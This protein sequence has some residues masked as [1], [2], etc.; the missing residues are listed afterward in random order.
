MRV[1]FFALILSS[2]AF[3]TPEKFTGFHLLNGCDIL[4]LDGKILKQIPGFHC[5]PMED[6][7]LITA[8]DKFIRLLRADGSIA[9]EIPGIFH[10]QINLSPDKK[11]ILAL[12]S[13]VFNRGGQKWREDKFFVISTEGNIL[14]QNSVRELIPQSEHIQKEIPQPM[15]RIDSVG[16][17][18]SHF[19]SI[20]EIPPGH[21]GSSDIF[22]EGHIVVNSL[23]MGIYVL[24]PDL[25]KILYRFTYINSNS[26][27]VHDVRV[28][29]DGTM[30]LFNNYVWTK[31]V[32]YPM[33]SIDIIDPITQK[34][35]YRYGGAD[36]PH[37]FSSNKGGVEFLND[38]YFFYSLPVNG[39][40]LVSRKTKK[41]VFSSFAPNFAYNLILTT[42]N[43]RM[44]DLSGF[45]KFFSPP[46]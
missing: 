31:E 3:A 34:L 5:I 11:R 36:G 16:V 46:K 21:H 29:P 25:K 13:E 7:R 40:H 33:S 2:I 38:D 8:N 39:G 43:V 9:W 17:E 15:Q 19:N 35:L 26:H 22:K 6:G 4:S 20:H 12:G 10:H 41:V 1:V 18:L 44:Q 23:T 32:K 45:L 30:L 37:F 24:T 14:A 28:L 27:T 42:Q